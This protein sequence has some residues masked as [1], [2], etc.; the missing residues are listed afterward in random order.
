MYVLNYTLLTNRSDLFF[1]SRSSFPFYEYHVFGYI[2]YSKCFHWT[3]KLVPG[4]L[5]YEMVVYVIYCKYH[6]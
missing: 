2:L 5:Y 4:V 1:I 3:M 6:K